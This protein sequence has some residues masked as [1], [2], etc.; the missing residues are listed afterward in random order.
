MDNVSIHLLWPTAATAHTA[1]RAG[2]IRTCGCRVGAAG[3]RGS[4]APLSATCCP[5]C[6]VMIISICKPNELTDI[7]I[8][9][10]A[11]VGPAHHRGRRKED[12]IP[13]FHVLIRFRLSP[14][15]NWPSINLYIVISSTTLTHRLRLLVWYHD[16]GDEDDNRMIIKRVSLPLFPFAGI[17]RS[18]A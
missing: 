5:L 3:R 6:G 12:E 13:Q 9:D 2:P 16:D 14:S 11:E 8:I 10:F 1:S 7:I 17:W 4:W 18:E 15:F